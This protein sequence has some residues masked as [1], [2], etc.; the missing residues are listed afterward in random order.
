MSE[1]PPRMDQEPS[2]STEDDEEIDEIVEKFGEASSIADINVLLRVWPAWIV[3]HSRKTIAPVLRVYLGDDEGNVVYNRP[4][5]L[6][7]VAD[8]ARGLLRV[9]AGEIVNASAMS[10]YQ[11]SLPG[12]AKDFLETLREV[13]VLASDALKTLENSNLL[14]DASTNTQSA[15]S[16]S[17]PTSE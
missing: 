4:V 9:V 1:T 15:P 10:G 16:P 11:L 14:P 5:V 7:A 6:S 8:L 17:S 3:N 13:Q 12:E 2:T